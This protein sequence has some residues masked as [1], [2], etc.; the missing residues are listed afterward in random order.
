MYCNILDYSIGKNEI[1]V[2][3]MGLKNFP[4]FFP[5]LG[6]KWVVSGGFKY[7]IMVVKCSEIKWFC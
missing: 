2:P 1:Y 5:I 7:Q 6:Q 3:A 4:L